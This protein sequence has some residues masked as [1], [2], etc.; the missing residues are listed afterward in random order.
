MIKSLIPF[1]EI[2]GIQKDA[3]ELLIYIYNQ[4]LAKNEAPQV[5]K[6]VE[7]TKWDKDRVIF[8]LEY[9]I[10]KGLVLGQV[11]GSIG[12]TKTK[13]AVVRDISPEGIE[14]IEDKHKTKRHFSH[15]ID[16]KIYKYSWGETEA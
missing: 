2:M 7:V 16:L 3:E 15:T 6:L 9:L 8:A 12:T 11:I 5:E 13:H 1:N 10:R 14:A 4:K